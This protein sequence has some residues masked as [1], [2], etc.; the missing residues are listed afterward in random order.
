MDLSYC[1]LIANPDFIGDPL[2]K[3]A[4]DL[5]RLGLGSQIIVTTKNEHLCVKYGVHITHMN[6]EDCYSQ[7]PSPAL[8]GQSS[9]SQ[10]WSQWP[11]YNESSIGVTFAILNRY[12]QVIS[13]LSLID[14]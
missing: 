8:H 2:K 1:N 5:Y 9:L 14:K 6:A 10:P 13:S 7:E 4:G 3:F 12:L 11:R